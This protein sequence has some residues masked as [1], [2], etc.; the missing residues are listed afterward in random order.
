M[1]RALGHV[2]VWRSPVFTAEQA[3]VLAQHIASRPGFE[4][5]GLMGYEAQ[6][7]GVGNRPHGN[8]ARARVLD[9]MQHQ[10]IAE[11]ADRRGAVVQAV[12][13]AERS[14][15]ENRVIEF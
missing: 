14:A 3:R 13:T 6:I 2:G 12:L 7:A 11:I 5:V 1:T 10:S 15:R 4:L 9:W 8:P